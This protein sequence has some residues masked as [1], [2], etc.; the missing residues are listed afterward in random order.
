VGGLVLG[1]A[2]TF[3]FLK[4][5]GTHAADARTPA[6]PPPAV[7]EAPPPAPPPV[8]PTAVAP[9]TEL[10]PT[11]PAPSADTT[12]P[13]QPSLVVPAETSPQGVIVLAEERAGHRLFV[14]GKVVPVKSARAVVACGTREIRVGRDGTPKMLDVACGR[15]TTL[16]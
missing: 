12:A 14:D 9:P 1:C 3:A 2:A 5:R 4:W 15:E 8:T 6:A 13:A 10:A 7:S 11:P 16:P